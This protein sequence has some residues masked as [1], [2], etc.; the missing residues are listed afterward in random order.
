MIQSRSFQGPPQGD[1]WEKDKGMIYHFY[2]NLSTKRFFRPFFFV[3]L[4]IWPTQNE[5][6]VKTYQKT[7]K[8]TNLNCSTEQYVSK[9]RKRQNKLQPALL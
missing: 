3:S 6:I 9:D 5:N 2:N 7:E 4:W 8:D 1:T